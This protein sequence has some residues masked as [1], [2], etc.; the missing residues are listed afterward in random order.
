[1]IKSFV[2]KTSRNEFLK[3][4]FGDSAEEVERP[5]ARANKGV[6]IPI[7]NSQKGVLK[8][9]LE[10]FEPPTFWFVAKRSIQL[11]YKRKSYLTYS[12]ILY[13]Q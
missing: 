4:A 6:R 7:K 9:R 1:M 3:F 10:G 5:F 13:Q 8:M 2:I 11:G 12:F